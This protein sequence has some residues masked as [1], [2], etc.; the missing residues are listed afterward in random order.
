MTGDASER[1]FFDKIK[2]FFKE[3]HECQVI[4]D[5]VVIH[6][7][8]SKDFK[9]QKEREA[10]FFIVSGCHKVI[11][12]IEVKHNWSKG[13]ARKAS[14]Q[15][16]LNKIHL[17]SLLGELVGKDS[18]WKYVGCAAYYQQDKAIKTYH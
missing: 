3:Q 14:E 11:I 5:L 10:D 15:H 8:R 7:W 17:E 12:N 16:Y 1:Y 4:R 13:N 2:K 9:S 6:G 18:G